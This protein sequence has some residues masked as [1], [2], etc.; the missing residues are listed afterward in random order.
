MPERTIVVDTLMLHYNG[1]FNLNEFYRIQDKFFREKGFDKY[2]KRN[3]EQ[4]LK[5]HRQMMVE[6]EPWKKIN[7]Y[8]K[9]VMKINLTMTNVKDV[10]VVKDNHKV[11]L[12]QGK[13]SMK[14]VGYLETDWESKWEGNPVLLFIRTIFDQFIYK[15]QMDKYQQLV[16]ADVQH[17]YNMLQSYLNMFKY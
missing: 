5:N 12:Q 17:L 13:I 2:E 11:T 14:F 3:E 4:V 9:E 8:A 15:A 7:D 16:A 6:M 10:V 1:V